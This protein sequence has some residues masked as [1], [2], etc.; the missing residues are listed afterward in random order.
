MKSEWRELRAECAN[1]R[2]E[3]GSC[4]LNTRSCRRKESV[5]QSAVIFATYC[6]FRTIVNCRELAYPRVCG[7]EFFIR[8]PQPQTASP[9]NIFASNDNELAL[10]GFNR[11]ACTN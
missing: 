10:S 6:S 8:C 11:E 5:S 3:A 2:S 1:S 4:F 7:R 9:I